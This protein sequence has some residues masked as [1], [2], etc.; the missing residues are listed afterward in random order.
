MI[1]HKIN[2]IHFIPESHYSQYNIL[3]QIHKEWHIEYFSD[4]AYMNC[5]YLFIIWTLAYETL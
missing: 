3:I 5:L 1:R 4:C 2:A